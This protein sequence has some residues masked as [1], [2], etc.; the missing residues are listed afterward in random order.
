MELRDNHRKLVKHFDDPSHVRELTFSCYGRR[1]LLT[2]D[3]GREMLSRA[4][5]AANDRHH[6]RLTAFVYMPEHV[7]LLLFPLPGA[8]K[9]ENLLRA[10]IRPYSYR[11]KQWLGAHNTE[12]LGQLT[13]HQRPGI[14]TFRYWQEGPGYDRNLKTDQA[15][16][17]SIEYIHLNPV[18]RKFEERASGWRWSSARYYETGLQTDSALPKL[19]PLPPE[20]FSN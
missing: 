15:V 18:R 20:W 13:V 10:I 7:H 17:A 3:V 5:D 19:T 9:V 6:W 2:N 1:P 16:S 14:E 8:S 12:L 11:I 4:I